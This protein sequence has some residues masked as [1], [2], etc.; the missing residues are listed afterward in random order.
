MAGIRE[1]REI[2]GLTQYQV[3]NLS[4]LERSRISCAECAHVR[5]TPAE[6]DKL[7]AAVLRTMAAR[8]QQFQAVLAKFEAP[9]K[10]KAVS[11]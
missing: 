8:A 2:L 5:L 4:G 9:A 11:V 10:E 1:L 6:I 7:K 3:A